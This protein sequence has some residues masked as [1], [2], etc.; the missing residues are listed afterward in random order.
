MRK[1]FS[2]V[3]NFEAEDVNVQEVRE[4]IIGNDKI[5]ELK[6][7]EKEGIKRAGGAIM[8]ASV[9]IFAIISINLTSSMLSMT[10]EVISVTNYDILDNRLLEIERFQNLSSK[11]ITNTSNVIKDVKIR[12]AVGYK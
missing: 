1:R 2:K 5:E 10:V 12:Q 8:S 3:N 7:L 6:R 4:N 9:I 11:L